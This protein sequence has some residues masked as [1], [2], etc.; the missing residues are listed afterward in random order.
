MGF[1]KAKKGS[2]VKE[3]KSSEVSKLKQQVAHLKKDNKIL[4]QKIKTLEGHKRSADAYIEQSTEGLS[5]EKVL[6]KVEESRE[7]KKIEK[8][9]VR[10]ACPKC[11]GTTIKH[12]PMRNGSYLEICGTCGDSEVKSE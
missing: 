7:A 10:K 11:L 9:G 5:L 3:A 2:I 4:R 1:I 8:Q 12:I 6:E